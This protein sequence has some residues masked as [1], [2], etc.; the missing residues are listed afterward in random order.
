M[1]IASQSSLLFS[2]YLLKG[3]IDSTLA[4]H[5]AI[6]T[7]SVY[8]DVTLLE[9][10]LRHPYKLFCVVFSALRVKKEAEKR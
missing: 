6:L 7:L 4:T 5:Q 1:G 8:E 10:C 9:N 2:E 3:Q